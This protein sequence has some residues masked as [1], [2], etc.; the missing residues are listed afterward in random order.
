MR[1]G[2]IQIP[3]IFKIKS[4]NIE[5]NLVFKFALFVECD[6]HAIRLTIGRSL[7]SEPI[8][9]KSETNEPKKINEVR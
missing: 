5:T 9:Q 6:L 2:N 8:I 4:L 7:P 1:I 3:L